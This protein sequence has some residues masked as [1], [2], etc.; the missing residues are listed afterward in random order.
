MHD[1][2]P[3]RRE[4]DQGLGPD[5]RRGKPVP[6]W[7]AIYHELHAGDGGDQGGE[8]KRIEPA[9]LV[10]AIG[11]HEQ[12][13]QGDRQGAQR[14]VDVEAPP[15]GCLLRQ[16]AADHRAEDRADQGSHRP[17]RHR[18][19]M[20]LGRVDVEQ[21]RLRQRH[22]EGAK[23]ALHH[24]EHH[25]FR[26]VRGD[27]AE[28]R[29]DGEA[30]QAEQQR[31]LVAQAIGD[32]PGGRRDHG[33][34]HDVGGQHP[35]NLVRRGGERAL[36]VRQRHVGDGAVQRVHQRRHHDREGDDAAMAI[37][38]GHVGAPHSRWIHVERPSGLIAPL[39]G[40]QASP[41]LAHSRVA[42]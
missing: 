38:L 4:P 14:Q 6:A 23:R 40:V 1:E 11:A 13:D 2:H 19:R 33:A 39:D 27:A 20:A 9:L 24:P 22:A 34:G 29:G 3:E 10:L 25:Q 18:L 16:I 35:S 17:G 8:A 21:H 32:P 30:D 31:V 28:H 5:L 26:Q 7:A 12:P 41:A 36:D 42:L 15:P 37:G